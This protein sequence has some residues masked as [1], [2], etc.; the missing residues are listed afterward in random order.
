MVKIKVSN[1]SIE[2]KNNG[3]LPEL[4]VKSFIIKSDKNDETFSEKSI[5]N[6]YLIL[7]SETEYRDKIASKSGRKSNP[8]MVN[9]EEYT[10]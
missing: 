4:E 3:M 1:F 10:E 7:M 9:F 8:L 2:D 5:K 6:D